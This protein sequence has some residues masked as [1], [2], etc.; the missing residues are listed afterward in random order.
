MTKG[1]EKLDRLIKEAIR[2]ENEA[3]KF[4]KEIE[5]EIGWLVRVYHDA[6]DMIFKQNMIE[7]LKEIYAIRCEEESH[8]NFLK[9]IRL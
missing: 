6:G 4:Y 8:Y 7:F 1:F 3:I 5:K 2:D 9:R